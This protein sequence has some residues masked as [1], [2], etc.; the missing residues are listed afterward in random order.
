MIAWQNATVVA[1]QSPY[2][3]PLWSSKL[4]WTFSTTRQFKT[5]FW[6]ARSLFTCAIIH[7][8][9]SE[10]CLLWKIEN[11]HTIVSYDSKY[12]INMS[13]INLYR[14]RLRWSCKDILRN[15][16]NTRNKLSTTVKYQ[17]VNGH[18]N[19]Y[20]LWHQLSIEQK[21]NVLC[22]SLVK[23]AIVRVIRT[24]TRREWSNCSLVKMQLC[25]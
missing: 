2:S 10:L 15:I 8:L 9:I 25:L 11:Q 12:A 7:C 24:G 4:M 1:H 22:G 13:E 16:Q 21:M 23:H 14:I 3:N 19:K 18:K 17:H 20:R 5:I 6:N